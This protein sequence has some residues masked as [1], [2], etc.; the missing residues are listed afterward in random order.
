MRPPRFGVSVIV[1]SLCI[2]LLALALPLVVLQ[3]FDRVIPFEA[4]ETLTLLFM[5]LCVVAVLDFALKWARLVLL[6]HEGEKFELDLG[7]RFIKRSLDAEPSAYDQTST[8]DHFERLNALAQ[9]RDYYCGQGRLSAIDLPFSAI[10]VLM[11]ALIG[12]WLVLVPLAGIA[13]LYLF[14]AV[15]QRA[16]APVFGKRKTLDGRRYSFLIECLSQILTVKADTME[17]QLLRRYEVLQNQSV[18]ISERLIR[19]SGLSQS[20]GALFSQASV[21]AMGL[22]GAFLVIQGQIGIAELAAC[23]LLNGR[24]VQPLLKMLSHWAQSESVESALSRIEEIGNLPQRSTEATESPPLVGH[25]D[26]DHVTAFPGSDQKR[27]FSDITF[28]LS[29]GGILSIV[30]DEGAARDAFM[31]MILGEETPEEGRILIDGQPVRSFREARGPGGIAYLDQNPV[32]FSG[33]LLENI[34]CFGEGDAIA[35]SLEY[36]KQLGLEKTVHRMPMGYST[37][38]GQTGEIVSSMALMQTI[39]L[40]R[41]LTLQPAIL[42]INDATSAMDDGAVARVATCLEALRGQTTLVLASEHEQ[43]TALAQQTVLL[44]G[45]KE[46]EFSLW[47]EDAEADAASAAAEMK[48]SA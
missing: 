14:K 27:A 31:R 24:T 40:V 43:L 12:G 26:F 2:N 29:A 41:A 5:G 35:R 25:L 22:F 28:D 48:W 46:Q 10:F 32:V 44:A 37:A 33:T 38:L 13:M 39:A 16:Q 7:D 42:L 18:D 34:S 4:Y 3:V 20:F 19:L 21:A 11:I 6:G 8:G 15:L 47:D 45:R 23:M 9:L 30:G 36:S 1:S 17:P